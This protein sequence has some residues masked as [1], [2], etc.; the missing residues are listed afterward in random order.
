MGQMHKRISMAELVLSK[1]LKA[2][3]GGLCKEHVDDLAE[4]YKRGDEIEAP[5]VWRC[6]G[7]VGFY[8]TRG[9]HR[10]AAL[11]KIGRKEVECVLKDG[12][13]EEAL[14]D[15]IGD[16]HTHGL[17]FNNKDKR[18]AVGLAL[19]QCPDLSGRRIAEAVGVSH[20][21]VDSVKSGVATVATDPKKPLKKPL[22][23]AAR[24]IK[25]NLVKLVQNPQPGTDWE[26]ET[27]AAVKALAAVLRD[28]G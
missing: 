9:W 25:S 3:A 17:R 18:H 8:L 23:P 15:A 1:R 22:S 26:E 24:S 12:T 27:I 20:A 7:I 10:V 19:K 16:N 21:F 5:V 6:K 11:K 13:W 14:L 28:V 2:R 4:A